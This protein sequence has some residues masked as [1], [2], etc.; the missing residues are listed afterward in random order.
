MVCAKQV[1]NFIGSSVDGQTQI[2]VITVR[3]KHVVKTKI[4]AV[5]RV[6]QCQGGHIEY[7]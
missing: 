4:S 6:S 3:E 1:D 7:V 5:N 2:P